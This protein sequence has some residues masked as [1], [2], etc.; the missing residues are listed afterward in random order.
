MIYKYNAGKQNDVVSSYCIVSREEF[1]GDIYLWLEGL[2][3][4]LPPGSLNSAQFI[5]QIQAQLN[6]KVLLIDNNFLTKYKQ[7]LALRPGYFYIDNVWPLLRFLPYGCSVVLDRITAGSLDPCQIMP[8]DRSAL[9]LASKCISYPIVIGSAV[10]TS[11][12]L[13]SHTQ[14]TAVSHNKMPKSELDN[15]LQAIE[16]YWAGQLFMVFLVNLCE[17]NLL[18]TYLIRTLFRR[19]ILAEFEGELYNTCHW[20]SGSEDSA[21]VVVINLIKLLA[22]AAYA[23][24]TLLQNPFF[25]PCL[26]LPTACTTPWYHAKG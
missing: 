13:I 24:M 9:D 26:P 17:G 3:G 23:E 8:C 4:K 14:V 25:I 10:L 6:L 12:G 7:G 18:N 22:D 11:D 2:F 5:I 15:S 1:R 19:V 20:L 16:N 21:L